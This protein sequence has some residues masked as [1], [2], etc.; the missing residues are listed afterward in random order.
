MRYYFYELQE[1][2]EEITEEDIET[3]DGWS[4]YDCTSDSE[5]A[6][7]EEHSRW[8]DDRNDEK[9]SEDSC[10]CVVVSES[11]DIKKFRINANFER[12]VD[13]GWKK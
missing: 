5:E 10:N 7:I 2:E 3:V 4:D 13:W 12:N 11:G 6:A 1:P 8:L 9:T